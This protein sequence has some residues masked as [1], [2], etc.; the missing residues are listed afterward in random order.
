MLTLAE[1]ARE[2]VD[3]CEDCRVRRWERGMS[4]VEARR[5]CRV[6]ADPA[7]RPFA[8]VFVAGERARVPGVKTF[9][10]REAVYETAET[11]ARQWNAAP[12]DL[13]YGIFTVEMES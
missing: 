3:A 7:P 1:D 10:A 11:K 8:I 12:A 6:N 4:A 2:H 9:I 13:S 5:L